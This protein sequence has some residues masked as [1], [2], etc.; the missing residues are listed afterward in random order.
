MC[1]HH[2]YF[3]F[4]GFRA[5]HFNTDAI[6]FVRATSREYRRFR[7]RIYARLN[8]LSSSCVFLFD[9][10]IPTHKKRT[11]YLPV[12]RERGRRGPDHFFL[13]FEIRNTRT[14]LVVEKSRS[15]RTYSP[16][17]LMIWDVSVHH[18][19]VST[20]TY[21]HTVISCAW[22][23]GL[24]WDL[25]RYGDCVRFCSDFQRKAED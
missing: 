11:Y 8:S 14:F 7:S 18:R 16:S 25:S 21:T 4:F 23:R 2:F 3:L 17:L 12:K 15:I 1:I 9:M 24:S 13:S 22:Q 20:H 10:I 19:Y 5:L 6:R